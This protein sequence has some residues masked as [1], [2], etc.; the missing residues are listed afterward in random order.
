MVTD[1]VFAN[2]ER[3]RKGLLLGTLM[4]SDIL[5][6]AILRY[7]AKLSSFKAKL[8]RR[9]IVRIFNAMILPAHIMTADI[10]CWFGRD[11]NGLSDDTIATFVGL[12][13]A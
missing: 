1:D 2:S 13:I 4:I 12:S 7:M 10:I 6:L 11:L 5:L 9:K 8:E 3:D